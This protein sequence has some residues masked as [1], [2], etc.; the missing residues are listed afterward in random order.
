M[1]FVVVS[2]PLA[3]TRLA[4]EQTATVLGRKAVG[5][6]LFQGDRAV[7]RRH[8]VVRVLDGTCVVE[9][10]TSRNGTFVNGVPI[11]GPTALGPDDELCIGT[12]RLRLAPEPD[13][14]PWERNG[15]GAGTR[16]CN[17]DAGNHSHAATDPDSDTH[18][19]A[20]THSHAD[21]DHG[22]HSH[23]GT[24]SHA[25]A[26]TRGVVHPAGTVTSRG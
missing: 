25:D 18:T 17:A 10:L 8:A 7:S 24:H 3:G 23:A 13:A 15:A 4:V 26:G 20:G 21:A 16:P 19:H 11:E 6:A 22:P 9:D 1:A 12:I 5:A 14:A 2:G